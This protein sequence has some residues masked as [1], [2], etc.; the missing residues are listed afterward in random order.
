MISVV[1]HV[2][3]DAQSKCSDRMFLL[4]MIRYVF[5]FYLSVMTVTSFASILVLSSFA[6]RPSFFSAY[7]GLD[8]CFNG[9]SWLCLPFFS[10]EE[11]YIERILSLQLQ[12][13]S[14]TLEFRHYVTHD[15][16]WVQLKRQDIKGLVWVQ[17]S[18]P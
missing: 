7:F 14:H 6:P 1:N 15:Q 9:V 11:D 17:V 5:S 2:K 10:S 16:L 3:K 4:W 13:I 8:S 18:I 12:E